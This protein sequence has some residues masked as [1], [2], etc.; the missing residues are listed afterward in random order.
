MKSGALSRMC[1]QKPKGDAHRRTGPGTSGVPWDACGSASPQGPWRLATLRQAGRKGI[2]LGS[3][4]ARSPTHRVAHPEAPGN[5]QR[6]RPHRRRSLQQAR[7]ARPRRR[8]GPLHDGVHPHRRDRLQQH[9]PLRRKGSAQICSRDW[10]SLLDSV[11]SDNR[12][13]SERRTS[14]TSQLLPWHILQ[15]RCKSTHCCRSDLQL[16]MTR[17]LEAT[18]ELDHVE[19]HTAYSHF[20]TQGLQHGACCTLRRTI[21][22]PLLMLP[23]SPCV[24]SL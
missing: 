2:G 3:A 11:Q 21:F 7:P 24:A 8:S 16:W 14:P 12:P 1:R 10:V 4:N 23:P 20:V 17:A 18:Q 15:L 9:I 13:H 19:R 6:P 5:P 22:C